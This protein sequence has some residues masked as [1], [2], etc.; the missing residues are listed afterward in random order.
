MLKQEFVQVLDAN[1]VDLDVS[2]IGDQ[3]PKPVEVE[4]EEED[5]KY[6]EAKV[7]S[8]NLITLKEWTLT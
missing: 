4:E 8:K 1:T 7:L 3:K 6:K 2:P 5:G